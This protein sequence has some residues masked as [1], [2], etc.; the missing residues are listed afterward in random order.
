MNDRRHCIDCA[1]DYT[2]ETAHQPV[3]AAVA[4]V[5]SPGATSEETSQPLQA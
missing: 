1:L 3:H 2:D 5:A 4:S